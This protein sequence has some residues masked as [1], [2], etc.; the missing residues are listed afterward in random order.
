MSYI[1][2]IERDANFLLVA[3]LVAIAGAVFFSEV[4]EPS[5]SQTSSTVAVVFVSTSLIIR[6]IA[7]AVRARMSD[8]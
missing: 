6:N 5:A 4:Q 7:R 1:E 3:A 8:A 2:Q